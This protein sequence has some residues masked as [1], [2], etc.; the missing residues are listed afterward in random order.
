MELTEQIALLA[1]MTFLMIGLLSGVWK[2]MAIR[3][4]PDARAPVYVDICHRASLLY[5]FACVLLERMVKVSQLP[6]RI[7][8]P[9]LAA[10]ILFFGLAISTYAVHGWLKDTENQLKMPHRIGAWR[11]PPWATT[12]FM[13]ALI[14]GEVGGVAVLVV[15]VIVAL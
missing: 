10:P 4:S 2:Y 1:A 8:L 3:S 7:E 15:G 9:A 12:V 14:V 11:L 13:I 6:E 5:A